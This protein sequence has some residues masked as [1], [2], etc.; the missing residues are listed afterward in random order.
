MYFSNKGTMDNMIVFDENRM[1]LELPE[2]ARI[3]GGGE[4]A[5]YA[6]PQPGGNKKIAVKIFNKTKLEKDGEFLLGKISHMVEVGQKNNK[7]LVNYPN[8]AW[9]QLA[10]Y[11]EGGGFV[12]YGMRLAKG[13]PL[14][15]LAHPMLY[16]KHFPDMDREK[17]GE[18]L[19][20]LWE[21]AQFLHDFG[22]CIGDVNSNNVLCTE[23]YGICWIDTDSFQV[24]HWRCHVGRPEMTPP[25]HL[26]KNYADIDRTRESDF[27]S[28]AILTFQCLMLGRHPYDHIRGGTPVENLRKGHFPYVTGGSFPGTRGGVP[29]GQWHKIWSNYTYSVME[30]FVQALKDGAKNPHLRPDAEG[31]KKGL[32]HNIKMINAPR[33]AYREDGSEWRHPREM[34]PAEEK[35]RDLRHRGSRP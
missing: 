10:A 24:G 17:V 3:G 18:M 8:V 11:D 2:S 33:P 12:G 19:I 23:K 29:L 28:L 4:G 7:A 5:V 35:P 27:F 32:R 31:W 13:K 6:V 26:D 25:E 15:R 21:S 20:R 9:P 34:I 1:P 16:K 22:I 30:L 14:S